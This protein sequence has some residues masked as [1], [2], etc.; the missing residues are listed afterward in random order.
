MSLQGVALLIPPAAAVQPS[1]VGSVAF[2]AWL[3][4]EAAAAIPLSAIC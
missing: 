1:V 4:I 3:M 2:G